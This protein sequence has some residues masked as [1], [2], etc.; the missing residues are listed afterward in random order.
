MY[1]F[2]AQH[3]LL[4]GCLTGCDPFLNGMEPFCLLLRFGDLRMARLGWDKLLAAHK[5]VK[6]QYE[7]GTQRIDDYVGSIWAA[8]SIPFGLLAAGEMGLLKDY[9]ANS[10]VGLALTCADVSRAMSGFFEKNSWKSETGHVHSTLASWMLM[11]QALEA[12]TLPEDAEPSRTALRTWLPPL[13]EL[14]SILEFQT[15]FRSQ[16]FGS[17]HPSLL[18]ATLHGD[19]L[20]AW[21][22][23]EAVASRLLEVEEFNPLCRIE[24]GRLL[25][26]AR[27]ALGRHADARAAALCAANEAARTG[28]RWLEVLA[29]RDGLRYG[30]GDGND[31]WWSRLEAVVGRLA[32]SSKEVLS[33][34]G[35]DVCE[36]WEARHKSEKTAHSR[37]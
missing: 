20:G 31:V 11:M 12:M 8:Y 1:D 2:H 15:A 35:E 5:H 33:A 30:G 32:A 27:S 19:R 26:R 13:P 25:S 7:A 24:S 9:L 28:C 21:D 3:E 22:V 17:C 16:A 34:L 23:A 37:P 10:F 29:L 18:C 14:L 4:K 6:Q 36:A